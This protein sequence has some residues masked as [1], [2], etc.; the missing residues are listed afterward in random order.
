MQNSKGFNRIFSQTYNFVYIRALA[1]TGE[2][3]EA[4][5]L[6][7]TVYQTVYETMT[8]NE[9]EK[10]LY[11]WLGKLVYNHGISL[12]KEKGVLSGKREKTSPLLEMT[13]RELRA[14]T[15]L[16]VRE[17]AAF[18]ETLLEDVPGILRAT[19]LAFYFD[20]LNIRT[21]ADYFECSEGLVKGRLNAARNMFRNA[22]REKKEED[23]K[24]VSFAVSILV[25]ALR[26]YVGNRCLKATTA[27]E[28]YD[29]LC[30]K[31]EIRT[32]SI[33]L[34]GRSFAGAMRTIADEDIERELWEDAG[35]AK[36][37]RKTK[38]DPRKL[39]LLGAGLALLITVI[40]FAA[41]SILKKTDKKEEQKTKPSV[42]EKQDTGVKKETAKENTKQTDG[43]QEKETEKE[44]KT[45]GKEDSYIFPESN[46][47]LL[48]QEEIKKHTKEELRIARNEIYAR[49]GLIFE[50]EDLQKYFEKQRWYK[51]SVSIK[52]FDKKINMSEIEEKNVIAIR[53]VENKL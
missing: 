33:R 50:V 10:D 5:G 28:I 17:T 25:Q 45:P 21:I 49:H 42:V 47:R 20:R 35:Q 9:E 15:T 14:N 19:L 8:G 40:I 16:D 2:E 24:L 32:D 39:A 12:L 26:G 51:P 44:A 4:E 6:L 48:T 1:M 13:E 3:T 30:R 37:R 34:E 22:I 38:P 41:V 43:E 36:Q 7:K 18:L 46:T 31:L 11:K 53:G 23:P 27:Q 52:D 29:E